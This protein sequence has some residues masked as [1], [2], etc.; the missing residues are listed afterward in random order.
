MRAVIA[1]L[2]R[3]PATDEPLCLFVESG[4]RVRLPSVVGVKNHGVDAAARV[5]ER[6]NL[7]EFLPAT[8]RSSLPELL[9]SYDV[10]SGALYTADKKNVYPILNGIPRLQPP[11]LCQQPEQREHYRNLLMAEATTGGA[12]QISREWR[13]ILEHNIESYGLQWESFRYNE[14]TW[15]RSV[16]ERY[17]NMLRELGICGDIAPL[18]GK[19]FVDAACG[20]GTLALHTAGI[21]FEVFAFDQTISVERA[22]A[23]ATENSLPEQGI[24]HFIEGNLV[25]PPLTRG[26]FDILYCG[27][28]VHFTPDVEH[29][30]R[31]LVALIKSRDSRIFI[32]TG[33]WRR[34]AV[35]L[36]NAMASFLK[37]FPIQLRKVVAALATAPYMFIQFVLR[38]IQGRDRRRRVGFHEAYVLFLDVA[39]HRVTEMMKVEKFE[40]IIRGLPFDERSTIY[41]GGGK[42]IL[43]IRH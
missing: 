25:A 2:L 17:D 13:K 14:T 24:V 33:E 3:C 36:Y 23:F 43:A 5:F 40:G 41:S 39:S 11:E 20:N 27:G 29:T 32:W 18:R 37:L 9:M 19:L 34:I 35:V 28:A 26:S 12:K 30:I 10:T 1:S 6:S 21:G 22:H 8:D 16:K 42:G 15:G 4:A 7:S 31:E 38:M